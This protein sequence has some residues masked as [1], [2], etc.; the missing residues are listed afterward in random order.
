MKLTDLL[1]KPFIRSRPTLI[2]LFLFLVLIS[3][4]YMAEF[5]G[6]V[7]QDVIQVRADRWLQVEKTIG[8]VNF[9]QANASRVA[10]VG[11]RLQSPGDGV[12]TGKASSS[13]LL[14]DTVVGTVDITESTDIRIQNLEMAPDNGRITR[15]LVSKGQAKL[16]LRPFTHRGSRMEI[17]TPASLSAVRGTTF[18]LTVQPNGKTG[19][20]VEEGSVLSDAVGQSVEVRGGFQNFTIPGETPSLPVPLRDDTTLRHQF[21]RVIDRGVRKV[22]LTGQVDPVNSVVVDGVPQNTDR[23]G[24]FANTLQPLPSSLRFQVVV[25][26]PL[27]KQQRYDLKFN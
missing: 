14:V 13:T 15:L 18:G 21:K 2:V 26:T 8:Q 6:A 27:G 7:A 22:Q 25:I 24:R 5:N 1:L 20:A 17:R 9:L 19:L 10:R 12:S 16:R 11:D 23:E 3:A 4:L